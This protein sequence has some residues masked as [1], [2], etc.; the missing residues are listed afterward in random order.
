MSDEQRPD[1][2]VVVPSVNGW[3]DLRGA[4]DALYAQQGGVAVEVLVVERVGDAVRP[5]LRRAFPLATV[6]EVAPTVTIP[7]MRA[8]AFDAA[9]AEIIGVIEDHVIE[10]GRASCRERV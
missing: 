3:A 2:S 8:L 9:R 10:I 1:L 7:Q 6:I 4:L 5:E